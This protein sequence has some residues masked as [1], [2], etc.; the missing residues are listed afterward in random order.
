MDE[1][2][3]KTDGKI[4]LFSSIVFT[5]KAIA[6]TNTLE[7]IASKEMYIFQAYRFAKT[8]SD[9]RTPLIKI[10]HALDYENSNHP[11]KVHRM[12][13]FVLDPKNHNP[14]VPFHLN[15]SGPSKKF[16]SDGGCPK[17][18]KYFGDMDHFSF[19][20]VERKEYGIYKFSDLD[21][22]LNELFR[23]LNEMGFFKEFPFRANLL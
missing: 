7:Q 8:D 15:L 17:C 4:V 10:S 2:H 3:D 23:R 12:I 18:N 9:K 13:D 6:A 22:T 11:K 14:K 21:K 5:E 20:Y 16:I 1:L 19:S